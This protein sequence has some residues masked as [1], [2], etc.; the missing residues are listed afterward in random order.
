MDNGVGFD[1]DSLEK[2]YGL[3][4]IAERVRS[5]GGK[6]NTTAAVG[7]GVK[8]CAELPARFLAINN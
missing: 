5:L 3:N 4:G 2:G 8:T 1:P 6:I 7:K